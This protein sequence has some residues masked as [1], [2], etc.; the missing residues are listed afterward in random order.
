[1]HNNGAARKENSEKVTDSSPASV[2]NYIS[3]GWN[4]WNLLRRTTEARIAVTIHDRENDDVLML[5][6][7]HGRPEGENL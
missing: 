7:S 3:H 4:I 1:M 2:K 6:L 5:T